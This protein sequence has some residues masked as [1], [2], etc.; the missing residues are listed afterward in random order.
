VGEGL[1]VRNNLPWRLLSAP[2]I[3]AVLVTGAVSTAP[4]ANA[5]TTVFVNRTSVISETYDA[6]LKPVTNSATSISR[7]GTVIDDWIANRAKLKYGSTQVLFKYGSRPVADSA[8]RYEI[9][10]SS[11]I[12]AALEGVKYG[13]S[14]Y[15]ASVSKNYSTFGATMPFYTLTQP[16]LTVNRRMVASTLAEWAY[17]HGYW[18]AARPDFTNVRVGDT[19][20]WHAYPKTD[21]SGNAIWKQVSHAAFVTKVLPDGYFE[22]ADATEVTSTGMQLIS[23]RTLHAADL[24]RYQVYS[25]ARFPLDQLWSWS[26]SSSQ[27]AV[28]LGWTFDKTAGRWTYMT[29]S[30]AG[31][32]NGW[33]TIDG[34]W[35]YFDAYGHPLFG[36][37]SMGGVTR[38][39]DENQGAV[40]LTTWQGI[41]ASRNKYFG[42]ASAI[43]DHYTLATQGWQKVN[44]AWYYFIPNSGYMQRDGWKSV[45][46]P[47]LGRSSWNYFNHNGQAVDALYTES[48]Q[49][50]MALAGPSDYARG[51]NTFQGATR[52]FRTTVYATMA[53]GLQKIGTNWYYL[54]PTTGTRAYGWQYVNSR[55]RYFNPTTGVQTLAGT[56]YIVD[57]YDVMTWDSTNGYYSVSKFITAPNGKK[58]LTVPGPDKYATG[59]RYIG[60]YY[61]YFG[62]DGAAVTG[63][64]FSDGTWHYYRSSGTSAL[65]TQYIDG[66]TYYFQSYKV[67]VTTR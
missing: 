28:D 14:L 39:I 10:C 57:S 58:Y 25:A 23:R 45:Y 35:Y 31:Y 42:A 17:D 27:A 30:T 16:N 3:L 46:E 7:L 33:F 37:R 34:K 60:G 44:G 5:A 12:Q 65:G 67:G 64:Y 1:I 13:T 48:G 47:A 52:Y 56:A 36:E 66:K 51:W 40:S 24:H 63:W 49:T 54:R 41:L 18:F 43:Y 20:F 19:L 38:Y 29:S 55:W 61:Y 2:M 50:Y 62:S 8:G 4:A 22:V 21:S 9:D 15:T 11:F 59:Y 32:H 26:Q 6:P 53:T